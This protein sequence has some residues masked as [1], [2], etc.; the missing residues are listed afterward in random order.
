[1]NPL[2]VTSAALTTA[3]GIML[4]WRLLTGSEEEQERAGEGVEAGLQ[5]VSH[6]PYPASTAVSTPGE[7]AEQSAVWNDASS[8][9][10]D[11]PSPE[12]S[13]RS[14]PRYHH[15]TSSSSSSS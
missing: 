2:V 9:C 7:S 14:L 12:S 11:E 3:G 5:D 4:L 10:A 1:M 13:Q 15:H 6:E 8:Q